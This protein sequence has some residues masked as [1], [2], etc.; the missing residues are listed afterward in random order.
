MVH[1]WCLVCRAVRSVEDWRLVKSPVEMWWHT[2]TGG[3]LKGKLAN[4]VGSQYCYTTSERGVSSITTTDT[5]SSAASCRLNWRPRRF[6]WTRPF[7]RK[8]K[9]GFCAC[10]ITFQT[11]S[12]TRLSSTQPGLFNDAISTVGVHVTQSRRE[13]RGSGE[14][15]HLCKSSPWYF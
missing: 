11:L 10:A 2:G 9:C 3:E 12:K 1:T 14:V 13:I 4:G 6:K 15:E 5:H 7:S 8:T